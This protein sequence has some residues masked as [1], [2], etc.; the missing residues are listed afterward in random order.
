MSFIQGPPRP[1]SATRLLFVCT[2]CPLLV[3][4]SLPMRMKYSIKMDR[5]NHTRN[6]ETALR[7]CESGQAAGCSTCQCLLLT[8][9]PLSTA[10]TA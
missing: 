7:G 2:N 6:T 4:A 1:P 9:R 3:V 8:L 5:I 10:D